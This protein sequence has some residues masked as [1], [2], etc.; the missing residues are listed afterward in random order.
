MV[1]VERGKGHYGLCVSVC[2]QLST[3]S[4]AF[5]SWLS[6]RKRER[7]GYIKRGVILSGLCGCPMVVSLSPFQLS[8]NGRRSSESSGK[9]VKKS[10][11]PDRRKSLLRKMKMTKATR[12]GTNIKNQTNKNFF[13]VRSFFSLLHSEMPKAKRGKAN[14]RE[15]RKEWK[16]E[17]ICGRQV[18]VAC[19]DLQQPIGLVRLLLLTWTIYSGL[20][21]LWPQ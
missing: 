9:M 20:R 18:N 11:S 13:S 7:G 15:T 4:Y 10:C 21:L 17:I 2:L 5:V 16:K 8:A 14:L 6:K 3:S 12:K 19:I 1:V